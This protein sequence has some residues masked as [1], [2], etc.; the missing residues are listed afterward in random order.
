MIPILAH[1]GGAVR[2]AIVG[3]KIPYGSPS[4]P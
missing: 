1:P 3:R 4:P 2:V